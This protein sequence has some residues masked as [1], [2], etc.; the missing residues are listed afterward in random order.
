[1]RQ[2]YSDFEIILVDDGSTEDV[3]KRVKTS[4]RRVRYVRQENRGVSAARNLGVEMSAGRYVAFLDSDDLFAPRKLERQV[5]FMERNP[6]LLLS[7]TSY[8]YIDSNG[9]FLDEVRSGTFSGRVYPRIIFACP[10]ATST[11]MVRREAFSE[12]LK[13]DESVRA[14]EDVLMWSR[15]ARISK[16][17]GIDEVLSLVRKHLGMAAFSPEAQLA[18]IDNVVRYYLRQDKGSGLWDRRLMSSY[19]L[20]RAGV[21]YASGRLREARLNGVYALVR[22]PLNLPR[23]MLLLSSILPRR[24]LG[25]LRESGGAK[26]FTA[27]WEFIWPRTYNRSMR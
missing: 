27:V 17:A 23:F 20:F 15:V 1:M 21:F 16:I 18:G 6:D 10:I 24:L 5:S 13:F 4:S 11:V 12:G 26:Y 3:K 22:Y 8:A 19:Y 7:H 25:V 14:G 9:C 2:T